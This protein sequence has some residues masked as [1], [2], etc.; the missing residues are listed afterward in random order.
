MADFSWPGSS[1]LDIFT[2]HEDVQ[3]CTEMYK[4]SGIYWLYQF[5]DSWHPLRSDVLHFYLLLLV[6]CFIW[7]DPSTFRLQRPHSGK[8]K[9][10]SSELHSLSLKAWLWLWEW[11]TLPTKSFDVNV[12]FQS[13]CS[14]EQKPR[15]IPP[16]KKKQLNSAWLKGLLHIPLHPKFTCCHTSLAT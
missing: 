7:A 5:T 6:L 9:H 15:I 8:L 2:R 14:T 12:H 10:Q 16:P 4:L 13:M 3:R 1:V 11:F